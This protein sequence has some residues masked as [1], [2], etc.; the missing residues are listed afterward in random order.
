MII[1]LYPPES[2]GKGEAEPRRAVIFHKCAFDA[3]LCGAREGGGIMEALLA[4][5]GR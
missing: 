5:K 2:P 4:N 1:S 3:S